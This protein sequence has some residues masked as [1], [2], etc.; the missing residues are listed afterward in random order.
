MPMLWAPW[1]CSVAAMTIRT[2][3]PSP[4]PEHEPAP[5]TKP[6]AFSPS[7]MSARAFSLRYSIGVVGRDRSEE[8]TS[9]LQSRRDLHSFPT[10]RSSDL[11]AR[12]RASDEAEGVLAEHDVGQSLLVAV[13]DRGRGQGLEEREVAA[14]AF[15]G[16]LAAG[17]VFDLFFP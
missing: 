10:R 13:F 14:G 9:E 1:T 2:A 4:H 15:E 17:V 6:K 7:M 16:A 3:V 12:A 8:H 5:P 11:G